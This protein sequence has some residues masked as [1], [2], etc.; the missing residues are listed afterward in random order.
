MADTNTERETETSESGFYRL[1]TLVPGVYD[2]QFRKSGF[3][4]VQITTV[5]L[6]V[7]QALTLDTKLELSAKTET[8]TVQGRNTTSPVDTT[9]AQVSTVIDQKQIEDLPLVLRDPYQLVLLSP[10]ATY[11]NYRERR[12]L[13]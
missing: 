5:T 3:R 10:G 12:V 4:I 9:D 8:V 2:V 1:P 13:D 7:A 11:Y 6:T